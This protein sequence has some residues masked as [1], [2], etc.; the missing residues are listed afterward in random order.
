YVKRAFHGLEGQYQE[1]QGLVAEGSPSPEFAESR[2]GGPRLDR[3]AHS[4]S[5]QLPRP[6]HRALTQAAGNRRVGTGFGGQETQAPSDTAPPGWARGSEADCDAAWHT[7]GWLWP[8]DVAVVGR[9]TGRPRGCRIAQPQ[10]GA[11]DAQKNGM[12]KRM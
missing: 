12:T 2:C 9:R 8:M 1:T 11:S 4:R 3:W 5:R 6:H 10:D 7:T